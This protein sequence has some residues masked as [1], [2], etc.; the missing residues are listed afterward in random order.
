MPC[1]TCMYMYMY[2]IQCLVPMYASCVAYLQPAF[3]AVLPDYHQLR[4]LHHRT[5]ELHHVGVLHVRHL[6]SH[7]QTRSLKPFKCLRF[8]NKCTCTYMYVH[9][10]L[11]C[12]ISTRIF[13]SI[14]ILSL[15]SF[16]TATVEPLYLATGRNIC[17]EYKHY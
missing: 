4:R 5:G 9:V 12:L 3:G 10:A 17:V 11:A 1:C 14:L 8:H 6:K 16:C 15:R 7:T 2:K 13:R